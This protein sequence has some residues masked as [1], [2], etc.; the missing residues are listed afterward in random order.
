MIDLDDIPIRP[1]ISFI[2][3]VFR[4]IVWLWSEFLFDTLGWWLGWCVCR[5]ITFGQF[6]REGFNC[7]DDANTVT[8]ITVEL[9]GIATL[10][11]IAWLLSM[12]FDL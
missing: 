12:V 9:I 10:C 11:T 2:V 1:I 5:T 7:E 8:R 4:F 6:P 3:G